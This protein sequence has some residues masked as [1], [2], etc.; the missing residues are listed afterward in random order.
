VQADRKGEFFE[1]EGF[2]LNRPCECGETG[3][4]AG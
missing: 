4:P 2:L 3:G 1:I